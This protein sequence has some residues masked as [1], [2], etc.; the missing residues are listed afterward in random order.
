MDS[1]HICELETL[2][3]ENRRLKQMYTELVL[4]HQLAKHIIERKV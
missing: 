4:D 3:G 1:T 2:E